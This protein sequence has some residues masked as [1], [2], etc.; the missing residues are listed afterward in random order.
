MLPQ[1]KVTCLAEGSWP[2]AQPG[3]LARLVVSSEAEAVPAGA[4]EAPGRVDAELTAAVAPAGTLVHIWKEREGS[5]GTGLW[6]DAHG[7]RGVRMA[8][9]HEQGAAA[10]LPRP[11]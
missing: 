4:E 3:G 5:V 2:G 10:P 6:G 11:R 7:G 1:Q 8:V 9:P